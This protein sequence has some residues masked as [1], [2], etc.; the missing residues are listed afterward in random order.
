MTSVNGVASIVYAKKKKVD[1]VTFDLVLSHERSS[2]RAGKN[3]PSS[4]W[5]FIGL[6]GDNT[7]SQHNKKQTI[8]V[9]LSFFQGISYSN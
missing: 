8:L 3:K 9:T 1:N 2:Q 5:I 6:G 4:I 7:K